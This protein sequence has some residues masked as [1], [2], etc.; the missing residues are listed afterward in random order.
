MSFYAVLTAETENDKVLDAEMLPSEPR[1]LS[2]FAKFWE[3]QVRD[4]QVSVWTA[5]LSLAD[6][7]M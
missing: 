3:V 2:F 5:F 4:H 1:E 6:I 7:F